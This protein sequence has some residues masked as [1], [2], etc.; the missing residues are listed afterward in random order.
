MPRIA[1]VTALVLLAL[2]SRPA[3][4]QGLAGLPYN[5]LQLSWG[6]INIEDADV[7]ADELAVAGQ[8]E[9]ADRVFLSAGYSTLETDD[10]ELLGFRGSVRNTR[11]SLGA[12]LQVPLQENIHLVPSL[13]VFNA[14]ADYRGGFSSAGRETD[15]GFRS[16]LAVRALVHPLVEVSGGLDYT[17]VFDDSATGLFAEAFYYPVASFGLGLGYATDDDS[18]T[19]RITG[20]L[21]F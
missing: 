14:E 2:G 10:F 5:W 16:A 18:D 3:L 13:S 4:A 1:L 9:I 17:R 7:D 20:R 21:L 8:F 15:T 19:L 11:F 12:G 6:Q